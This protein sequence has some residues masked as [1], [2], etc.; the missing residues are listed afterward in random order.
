MD[1]YHPFLCFI[2]IVTSIGR[3]FWGKAHKKEGKDKVIQAAPTPLKPLKPSHPCALCD[4]VGHA[5]NNCPKLLHIKNVVSNTFPDPNIPEVH[6]TFPSPP[7][8]VNPYAWTTLVLCV[9]SMGI[10][11]ITIP[12]LKTF[13][14]LHKLY[15]TCSDSTSPL[16]VGFGPNTSRG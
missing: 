13:V 9:I 8:T 6:V 12:V 14:I 7:R 5:T 2:S 16:F 10:I 3:N 4:V 1:S 15:S 11:P